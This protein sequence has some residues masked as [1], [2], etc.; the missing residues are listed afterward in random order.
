MSQFY[1]FAVTCEDEYEV[2]SRLHAPESEV[3]KIT[4]FE[5]IHFYK[6]GTI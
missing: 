1:A 3:F 4:K 2:S 6:N 5:I